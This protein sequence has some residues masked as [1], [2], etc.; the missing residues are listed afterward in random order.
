MKRKVTICSYS[1]NVVL[2]YSRPLA[3]DD[4][5]IVDD[6]ESSNE[7]YLF[8]QE[9]NVS[10]MAVGL[11]SL[12][13]I[14]LKPLFQADLN[15]K[16]SRKVPLLAIN[17]NGEV[18]PWPPQSYPSVTITACSNALFTVEIA[19]KYSYKLFLRYEK[20]GRA[21][22]LQQDI[23]YSFSSW[24]AL[25]LEALVWLEAAKKWKVSEIE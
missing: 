16:Y 13:G 3:L 24:E 25:A 7:V 6:S 17:H 18:V 11:E 8:G 21:S 14:E 5:T 10:E 2:F 23:E 4:G 15:E 12:F 9:V 22:E 20:L 1:K 19:P